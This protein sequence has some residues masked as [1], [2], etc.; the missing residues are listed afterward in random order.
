MAAKHV[1]NPAHH[2]RDARGRFTKSAT[3][4]LKASDAKRAKA[5]IAGFTPTDLGPGSTGGAE[6]LKKQAAASA[7]ADDAVARYFAGGWKQTH[8]ELR[9]KKDAGSD[10]DVI[11]IDKAMR[12]LSDDVMLERRVSLT[13]FAHIPL[14]QLQGMKVRD[15]AY[16]PTA[17]Q[18]SQGEAPDG[19]VTIH[20]AVPA[21]TRAII[22]P[23]TGA[24][25]LDRDTET[26][27]SRVE[28]N[29]R[30][31]YDL[32]GIVI[33]RQDA[34]KPG[35]S[36]GELGDQGDTVVP[37]G[38]TADTPTGPDASTVPDG[39]NPDASSA[40][41]GGPSTTPRKTAAKK[42]APAAPDGDQG[43][44]SK[45][46]KKTATPSAGP[47]PAPAAQAAEET[48]AAADDP[49]GKLGEMS[50]RDRAELAVHV[51][52][53]GPGIFQSPLVGGSFSS[54]G[55]YV[56][57]GRDAKD[58]VD[59]YGASTVWGAAEQWARTHPEV[60]ARTHL[61]VK[62]RIEARRVEAEA[63]F[64]DAVT[65][66]K[67]GDFPA[68]Y[69]AVD[70]GELVDPT[71]K[72]N[73]RGWDDAR[74]ILARIEAKRAAEPDTPEKANTPD[75]STAGPN[76]PADRGAASG[77]TSD[78]VSPTGISPLGEDLTQRPPDPADRLD[79]EVSQPTRD[80]WEGH[81]RPARVLWFGDGTKPKNR[82]EIA[83]L[84]QRGTGKSA[85]VM[86]RGEGDSQLLRRQDIGD[87]MWLAP[88]DAPAAP[89]DQADTPDVSTAG[90]GTPDTG[91]VDVGPTAQ[92]GDRIPGNVAEL[93]EQPDVSPSDY[94]QS[95]DRLTWPAELSTPRVA[96]RETIDGQDV[97]IVQY[98]I[99]SKP[100][101]DSPATLS[102]SDQFYAVP[103]D[104]RMRPLTLSFHT[105]DGYYGQPGDGRPAAGV[106]TNTASPVGRYRNMH[107]ASGKSA[108]AA[109]SGAR[110]AIEKKNARTRFTPAAL[111]NVGVHSQADFDALDPNARIEPGDLVVLRSFNKLRTGVATKVTTTKVD[112]L[113][114]TPTGAY[115]T[116]YGTAQKGV[117]V[118]RLRS[119][120][121]ATD[122]P[123]TAAPLD[124]AALAQRLIGAGIA[125]QRQGTVTPPPAS[126]P[127]AR[128]N[129]PTPIPD[130]ATADRIR[131]AIAGDA[132]IGR[133]RTNHDLWSA[134]WVDDDGFVSDAGKEALADFDA[135]ENRQARRQQIADSMAGAQAASRPDGPDVSTAGTGAS[136]AEPGDDATVDPE[137]GG[138][139]PA[140]VAGPAPT[141]PA[142]VDVDQ[143]A[144]DDEVRVAGQWATV[145]AKVGG[146]VRVRFPDNRLALVA[147]ADIRQHR[148]ATRV[149]DMFGGTTTFAPQDRATIGLAARGD[150][151]RTRGQQAAQQGAVF[152]VADQVQLEGQ[153]ALLDAFLQM[154]AAD[155]PT[156]AGPVLP[157]DAPEPAR[158]DVPDDLTGWTDEQLSG[159]F[160]EVSAQAEYDEPGTLAIL[161]EW[162]RREAEMTVLLGRVPDD[163]GT[164]DDPDA[165]QLYADLTAHHGTMDTDVVARLEADLERRDREY[166]A[167]VA[168]LEAKRALVALDPAAHSDDEALMAALNAAGELDDVDATMRI[169]DEIERRDVAEKAE[170]ARGA[171]EAHQAAVAAAQAETAR[172]AVQAAAAQRRSLDRQM[173]VA[174]SAGAIPRVGTDRVV[175]SRDVLG[176]DRLRG[177]LGDDTD[178][179][180]PSMLAGL[181]EQDRA[182]LVFA[183]AGVEAEAEFAGAGED[184]LHQIITLGLF[185]RGG[186]DAQSRSRRAAREKSRR[187]LVRRDDEDT[188]LLGTY[189][190]EILAGDVTKLSDADLEAAPALIGAMYGPDG[191]EAFRDRLPQINA[192]AQ[193]RQSAAADVEARRAAGPAGPARVMS[194]ILE[195]SVL[196]QN[197]NRG[198]N[199]G[200]GYR[201]QD[202]AERMRRAKR[203]VFGLDQ[204]TTESEIKAAQ[205]K[206][207]R[208]LPEQSAMILAWYRHFADIDLA[209]DTDR[210]MIRDWMRGPAD[211]PD[212]REPVPA[213]PAENIAK[214]P[215]VWDAM[216]KQA[217]EDR[218]NGDNGGAVRYTQARARAYG[219][220][221]DP[222]AKSDDDMRALGARIGHIG[223]RDPR[224]EQQQKAAFIAE[225]RRLAEADGVDP[226][227]SLRFGPSAGKSKA[228]G[229]KSDPVQEAQINALV[230]KGEEWIDAY[231]Q[232]HQLDAEK[233]RRQETDRLVK[234]NAMGAAT[235]AAAYKA[236]YDEMVF[237]AHEAAESG[238]NGHMLND[239]GKALM[240]AG[241]LSTIELFSGPSA[242]AYKYASEDL[243]RWWGA[244]PP[245]RMTFQQWKQTVQG[246]PAGMRAAIQAQKGNEFA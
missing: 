207:P 6:W 104:A 145:T 120:D 197:T 89:G 136:A 223:N 177:L 106:S 135:N 218:N 114:S 92:V 174:R 84:T 211:D 42:A 180:D 110:A 65:A 4:V 176:P 87:R 33:P 93:L 58:L 95:A 30:G 163:L 202:A 37:D 91:T 67:A 149:D 241:K 75:T 232:V 66:S 164:L 162:E 107:L 215:Q 153:T 235:L 52:D 99:I 115:D 119:A 212:Y 53:A 125:R 9:T 216:I 116:W 193:R 133:G 168:D 10:P 230:A 105:R 127:V 220:A 124:D 60:M 147:P 143:V 194:P 129:P 45:P 200:H 122:T 27:I 152:D 151:G 233:L 80:R 183:A 21:G 159:L 32:Y 50:P 102:Y 17:L 222:D 100:N 160:A 154:P 23:D 12:P 210:A 192:E 234:A 156:A 121:L 209:G 117:G 1:W 35:R 101:I 238:T 217:V 118:R 61:E 134:G 41:A 34:A 112:A 179:E 208:S 43:S 79:P 25:V 47:R 26:A 225:W 181:S 172:V 191:E 123:D 103:A 72:V 94:H 148:P 70:A 182:R 49:G 201:G 74:A 28:P 36:A 236:H 108:S 128:I 199:G 130:T 83:V 131:T 86:V 13:M 167:G 228:V 161:G 142:P 242:K 71:H 85:H 187:E 90:T 113:V 231:A 48:A 214:A 98:A 20:M 73:F 243:K 109:L 96:A 190:Q 141:T 221:F 69:A 3:R 224:T 195:L 155:P 178:V 171:A 8:Q 188:M 111:A 51:E 196:E 169:V 64:Q 139:G 246:D 14:E 77:D 126:P 54:V 203:A 166:Q 185:G 157:A 239:E 97:A 144:V 205:R 59:K 237:S 213:L 29:G 57:E 226:F 56:G 198:L 170:T 165:M 38:D 138:T 5:A 19:M 184:E 82:G 158:V 78:K 81:G 206:D 55:R 46:V 31:G 39:E 44:D 24:I 240:L 146:Q 2:P 40:A 229:R 219:I 204:D 11:A 137:A 63:R 245:P 68:A 15:A 186:V 173:A 227:D 88:I 22:N 76:V 18:G 7:A 189:R 62:A 244:H 132:N 140:A 16:Q 175:R 150:V